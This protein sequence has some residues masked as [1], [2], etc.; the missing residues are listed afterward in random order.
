MTVETSVTWIPLSDGTRLSVR[1]W[2]DPAETAPQPAILEYLP[3]RK[4]DLYAVDDQAMIGYFAASGYVGVKVDIR[5]TGNSEGIHEDEYSEQETL[6]ALEV[7]A[8]IREQPWCS[9]NVGMFG[10]SYGG[11]NSLQIA[12]RR[13]PGLEGGHQRRLGR[14][15]LRPGRAPHRRVRP[16]R[17]PDLGLVAA[18]VRRAPAAPRRPR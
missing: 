14:R 17:R 10:I 15:P 1:L 18:L 11:F 16:Q 13:P 8:W 12:A 7:I 3:Y 4:D 5:G 9:G 2:R 6:D